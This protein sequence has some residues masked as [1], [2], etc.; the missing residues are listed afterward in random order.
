[1]SEARALESAAQSLAAEVGGHVGLV[2]DD[3]VIHVE[4]VEAA[5]RRGVGVDG[6]EALVGGGE[7]VFT[8]DGVGAG[9]FAAGVRDLDGFDQ[10]GG[11]F[12]DEGPVLILGGELVTAVDDG[13]AGSGGVGELEGFGIDGVAIVS[14]VGGDVGAVEA[15]GD[16]SGEDGVGTGAAGDV[17][18]DFDGV[19]SKEKVGHDAVANQQGAVG[20][21]V[22][23]AEVVLGDAPLATEGGFLRDEFSIDPLVSGVGLGV[24]HPV[25]ESGHHAV[26][27]V[28]DVASFGIG[29]IDDDGVTLWLVAIT[30]DEVEAFLIGEENAIG[31]EGDGA[32]EEE[33]FEEDG[34]LVYRAVTGGVLEDDDAAFG[35]VLGGAVNVCHVA[36]HFGDP[37]SAPIIEGEGDGF[38]DE[39][40]CNDRFDGEVRMDGEGLEGVLNGEDGSFWNENLR[41]D[42]AHF[43]MVLVVAILGD[44]HGGGS[45]KEESCQ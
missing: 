1:M 12:T 3:A 21:M 6:T 37:H 22:E 10:L 45:G 44:G 40:F 27:L 36:T 2:L 28:L 32:R 41:H 5:I 29:L 38:I 34:A 8:F 20:V 15:G 17:G 4:N 13:A 42:V 25:V 39:R 30:R 24:V 33:F 9:D 18:L 14:V 7:E 11:R 35:D 19:I 16:A 43:V 23:A 26:G 31:D